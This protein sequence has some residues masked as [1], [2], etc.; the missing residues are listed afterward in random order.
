MEMMEV[1]PIKKDI[2]G[3]SHLAAALSR[4]FFKYTHELVA[5]TSDTYALAKEEL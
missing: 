2:V 4:T 5:L 3:F 1:S